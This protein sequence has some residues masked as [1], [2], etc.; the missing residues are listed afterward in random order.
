MRVPVGHPFTVL[1]T[2]GLVPRYSETYTLYTASDDGVRVGPNGRMVINDW[3]I[4]SAAEDSYTAAL[5]AG[6][7]YDL[8]V[9]YFEKS[10]W[11]SEIIKLYWQSPH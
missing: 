10:G 2:G 11:S 6:H 7:R 8:R 4:H 9:E 1:W 5:E 3:S